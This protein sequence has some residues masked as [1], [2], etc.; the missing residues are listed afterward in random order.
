MT[1]PLPDRPKLPPV[2]TR[3]ERRRARAAELDAIEAGQDQQLPRGVRRRED[4]S[5]LTPYWRRDDVWI[6]GAMV[7]AIVLLVAFL[8]YWTTGA[9]AH[10]AEGSREGTSELVGRQAAIGPVSTV[11]WVVG[12]AI[13]V[14]LLAMV[15]Y[16][17][18]ALVTIFRGNGVRYQ[19]VSAEEQGRRQEVARLLKQVEPPVSIEDAQRQ[20]G[21][22][23]PDKTADP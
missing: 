18:W 2:P 20:L 22:I 4:G 14:F 13:V 9:P 3:E 7:F 8:A 19:D 17:V 16:V 11:W 5:W 12:I 6:V 10:P 23:A 21:H 15:G 1:W